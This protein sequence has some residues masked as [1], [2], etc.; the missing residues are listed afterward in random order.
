MFLQAGM[1]AE[2]T[3]EKIEAGLYSMRQVLHH[4]LNKK[5]SSLMKHLETEMK[6]VMV[7]Y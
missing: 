5:L 6:S 3:K 4:V 2:N 7:S 1:G